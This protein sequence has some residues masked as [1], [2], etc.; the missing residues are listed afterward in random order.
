[1][2]Q[3]MQYKLFFIFILYTRSKFSIDDADDDDIDGFI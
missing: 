2:V 1:M 3:T